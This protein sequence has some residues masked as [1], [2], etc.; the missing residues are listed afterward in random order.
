M[1]NNDEQGQGQQRQMSS[2]TDSKGSGHRGD[3]GQQSDDTSRLDR[4]GHEFPPTGESAEGSDDQ[5]TQNTGQSQA[6]SEIGVGQGA[7]A[8][9]PVGSTYPP[10]SHDSWRPSADPA[11]GDMAAGSDRDDQTP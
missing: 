10:E 2:G 5:R 4:D 8:K 11:A 9:Q 3:Q 7:G 1:D 6:Q